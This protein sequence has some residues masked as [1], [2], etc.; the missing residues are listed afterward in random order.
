VKK[1]IKNV[2]ENNFICNRKAN[3]SKIKM[4]V[5][6]PA[7]FK[8]YKEDKRYTVQFIDLEEA[9]TEGET[10]EEAYFNAAEVLTLTLDA[11]MDEKMAIPKPSKSKNAKLVAP[12]ARTQ[13]A[14]LI[15][16]SKLAIDRGD[17]IKHRRESIE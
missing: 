3:R 16:W 4:N 6:Y 13:T 9:I 14:L 10:L 12:S 5:Q 15:R 17:D 7:I 11:R 2:A 1:N 8:F